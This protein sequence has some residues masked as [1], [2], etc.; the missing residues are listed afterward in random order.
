M[1]NPIVGGVIKLG[2]DSIDTDVISPAKFGLSATPDAEEWKLIKETA[3][4]GIRKDLYKDVKPGD[5]LVA[6]KNYGYG[7]HRVRVNTVMKELGF[8]AVI[9]E[10]FARIYFRNSIAIGFPA[11]EVPGITQLVEEG[12]RLEVD[13]NKLRVTNLTNGK[14]LSFKPH[15]DMVKRI[16]ETGGIFEMMRERLAKEGV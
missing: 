8:A 1:S 11:Y 4:G 13:L 2:M 14:S 15:S 9:A 3:F 7:S 10:S 16:L 12:D 5:I 6:G